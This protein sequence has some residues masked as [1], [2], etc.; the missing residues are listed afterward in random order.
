MLKT[1][2]VNID[3]TLIYYQAISGNLT[4]LA[5]SVNQYFTENI[6]LTE[7][8]RELAFILENLS[9]VFSNAKDD[10]LISDT[11]LESSQSKFLILEV[12]AGRAS[13]F[14]NRLILRE[15]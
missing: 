6:E 4:A 11:K 2:D 13:S 8:L 7:S 10:M 1:Y 3:C 15:S 12:G 9:V 14:L 5:R